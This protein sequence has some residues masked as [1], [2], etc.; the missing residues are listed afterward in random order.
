MDSMLGF[1]QGGLKA[2][3][4]KDTLLVFGHLSDGSGALDK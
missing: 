4:C 2:L 1:G 3:N